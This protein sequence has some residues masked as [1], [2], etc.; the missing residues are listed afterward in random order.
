[1]HEVRRPYVHLVL[2]C[3][4]ASACF[5]DPPSIGSA[6]STSGD[7]STGADAPTTSGTTAPAG[8]SEGGTT[9]TGL[10]TGGEVGSETSADTTGGPPMCVPGCPDAWLVCEA[11]E[12]DWADAVPPWMTAGTGPDPTLDPSLAA[13]GSMSMRAAVEVGDEYSALQTSLMPDVLATTPYVI[14]AHVWIDP[15]CP[16]HM[17]RLVQLQLSRMGGFAYSVE[18]W[19]FADASELWVND[20]GGVISAGQAE[21]LAPGLWHRVEIHV[22]FT[23]DLNNPPGLGLRLD[24]HPLHVFGGATPLGMPAF[25][26]P[27]KLV[28]GPY[29][30]N[31]EPFSAPCALNFDE[32]LV[33]PPPM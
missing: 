21:P 15:S 10:A 26:D 29:V 2:A 4:L 1:M 33:A 14:V 6:D 32:V 13:C 24:D 20:N 16:Q 28:L 23:G 3:S 12:S 25:A 31:G 8:T 9:T 11:F 30:G 18:L 27:P 19:T 5:S 22:D 17:L 7:P